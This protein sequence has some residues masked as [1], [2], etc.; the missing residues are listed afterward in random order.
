M[1]PKLV[2]GRGNAKLDALEEKY[3]CRV[4]TFSIMSGY[5]CP[6]ANECLSKAVLGDNGRWSIQDGPNIK[7]RC[8]SASQE[9]LFSSVR[10]SR[11]ANM[12]IL[13][14]AAQPMGDIRA[15]T[16]LAEQIPSKASIIRI[17]VA[18]DMAT[19]NYFDA[20][21]YAANLLPNI[22]FYTYTKM[23]PLWIKR[24]GKIPKN[25]VLTASYGGK[26][27]H[28]IEQHNLRFAKVVYSEAEA[29]ELNLPIDH[30]DS[31]AV[32]NGGSFALL[33]HGVQPANSEANKAL[34]ALNGNGSYTKGENNV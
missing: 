17:H 9:I 13:D 24:L 3:G 31:H 5:T 10:E 26:F 21:C 28:L 15:G 20:W 12:A 11:I 1:V 4:Y 32:E 2:F 14:I 7:F 34:K 16:I 6:A 19:Q 30:D 29:T 33:I 18:G 8:F 23:L 27:D 22:K 25:L